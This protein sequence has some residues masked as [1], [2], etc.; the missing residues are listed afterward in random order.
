MT[1]YCSARQVTSVCP[2]LAL[3]TIAVLPSATLTTATTMAS[4]H[5]TWANFQSAGENT[6]RLACSLSIQIRSV[7]RGVLGFSCVCF[8]AAW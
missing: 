3:Q 8:S 5:T 1:G 4:V 6:H 7:V 2:S